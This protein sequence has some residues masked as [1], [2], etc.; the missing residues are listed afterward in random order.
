MGERRFGYRGFQ[1]CQ[2]LPEL[3][4]LPPPPGR[5]SELLWTIK[6]C[7]ECSLDSDK[8]SLELRTAVKL[9]T[10]A[11]ADHLFLLVARVEQEQEQEQEQETRMENGQVVATCTLLNLELTRRVRRCRP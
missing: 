10:S 4:F 1:T 8:R 11:S 5:L 3:P 2:S 9:A 7:L 6:E